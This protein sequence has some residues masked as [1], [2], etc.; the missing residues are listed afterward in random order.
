M[1]RVYSG[2]KAQYRQLPLLDVMSN[3]TY[4]A[5]GVTS[6]QTSR[7]ASGRSKEPAVFVEGAFAGWTLFAV[8]Q[9]GEVLSMP[10]SRPMPSI[11]V[12]CH[13]LR[14]G[15]VHHTWRVIYRAEVDRVLVVDVFDK[16]Q[17]KTPQ[18]IIETCR[19][20]LSSYDRFRKEIVSR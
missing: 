6:R 10:I 9:R 11:G 19:K 18:T 2:S 16:N 17:N 3:L 14:I 8:V 15:D 5:I 13:E 1:K 7:M 4:F 12:R 20:T